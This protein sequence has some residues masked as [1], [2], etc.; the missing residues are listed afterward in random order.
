M[1]TNKLTD[2]ALTTKDFFYDLPKELIA[3]TPA[4]PRDSSRLL[5]LHKDTGETEHRIFRDIID[6]LHEG[7]VLVTNDS[8]VIP[9]RLYGVKEDSGITVE[10]VLLRSRGLDVW[11]TLVRPGRRCRPGTKI[12][13]GDGLLRAEVLETV[14]GGNR[15]LKFAYEGDNIFHVLDKV[16]Q[17]P[18]PPYITE[19]LKD[20][21]RYQTVY[22]KE[23]GSAAAP[24]AGL[25]FTPELLERI[26]AKGVVIAPVMLHVGLGTF[27]PVK[28]DR[29]EEHEMH[30][31]FISVSK[32][33]A[34][35]INNRK[36]RV[37]AVGTT[38]CRTLESAS[39]ENGIVHPV[40]DD[41]KIFIY[42]GYRFKI[43]DALITNFHLPESTL[44]ML[45]SALTNR[46]MMLKTY[47]EAIEMKY[48]FFSFGDAMLIY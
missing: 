29:I 35:L 1:I 47:N 11:E 28:E 48:R 21:N 30:S 7:D 10:V 12:I 44:L 2:T 36:G 6:Y 15:L 9:A 3:Q 38:S 4:E 24:T 39:D 34:D 16:G 37:F 18:L 27:R 32:E 45:V 17:M 22:A 43:T 20:K 5:V 41:T 25:H 46:E 8:K 14:E 31:E 23:E 42:P 26:K 33:T 13:F 40:T 19:K